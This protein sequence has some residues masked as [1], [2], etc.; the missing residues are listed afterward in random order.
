MFGVACRDSLVVNCTN[1]RLKGEG[2]NVLPIKF[3]RCKVEARQKPIQQLTYKANIAIQ[4]KHIPPKKY[5]I[6]DLREC[7]ILAE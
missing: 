2:E 7:R 3:I 1:L 4:H 6:L 5:R